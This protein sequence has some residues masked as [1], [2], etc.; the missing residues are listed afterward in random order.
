MKTINLL[1]DLIN[2]ELEGIDIQDYPK[3]FDTY[4]SY[5]K[6]IDGTP[7]TDTELDVIMGLHHFY[8]NTTNHK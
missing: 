2:V 7:P 5:A 3:F 8:I 4:T 1:E 6:Y